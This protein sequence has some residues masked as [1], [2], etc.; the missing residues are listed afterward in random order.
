VCARQINEVLYRDFTRTG[1]LVEKT[2]LENFIKLYIN[3][4]PAY[5]LDKQDIEKVRSRPSPAGVGPPRSWA[6][7]LLTR[8]HKRRPKGRW[9]A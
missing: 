3:H 5:A 8:W 6:K 2:D 4:R 9:Y 1:E 7:R